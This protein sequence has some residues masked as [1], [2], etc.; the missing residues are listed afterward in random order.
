MEE[1][2][3]NVIA[4]F[5]DPPAS[6][7]D[8]Y[9]MDARIV[10]WEGQ[11]VLKTPLSALFRC[12]DAWCTFVIENGTATQRQL[13]LGHRSNFEAEVTDGLQAGDDVILYPTEQVRDGTRV[14]PRP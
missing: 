7:G 6:L 2:R 1:Q 8:G 14:Q 3:V 12:R 10:V 5:A 11:D 13:E 4:D 9:R